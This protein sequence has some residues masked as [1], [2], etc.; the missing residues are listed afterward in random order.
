MK[1]FVRKKTENISS[2][3]KPKKKSIIKPK[4]SIDFHQFYLSRNEN[5]SSF[6]TS[7]MKKNSIS[8]PTKKKNK[9]NINPDAL[10]FETPYMLQKPKDFNGLCDDLKTLEIQNNINTNFRSILYDLDD[11]FDFA[12]MN[13]NLKIYDSNNDYN[14][15]AQ[16]LKIV[17]KIKILPEKRTMNDLLQ[18]V[19]YIT[20]TKLGK[21]FLEGF[22]KK[23][24]FEKLITFCGAEMK[25]KFFKKGETVFRI[26]D[27]PDNFYIILFGKVNILKPLPKII[28]ITGN[29]YFCYLMELKKSKDEYLYNLCIKA[30]K[31]NFRID[32]DDAK[33]LGYIYIYLILEKINRNKTVDFG[34]VLKLVDMSYKDFDLEPEH[35]KER[36]YII[37][38]MRKIKIYLPDIS[39]AII[40]KYLFLID[41]MTKK[42]ITLYYYSSFLTLES[43]SHFG[44]S[45]MDSNTTR[46]AT[47]AAAEDTHTAYISC[48]SYFKNVVVEKAA[49][50][51]KK[52]QFLNSNFIFGKINQK[53]FEKKYFGLFI[54]NNYKKGDIIFEE[55]DNPENV[56]FIEEGDIELYSSKNIYELQKVI[57]YLEEKRIKFLKSNNDELSEEKDYLFTYDKLH[58]EAYELRKDIIRKNKNTILVLNENE[59]LGLLSF[60]FGYPYFVTSMVRSATAKIYKIDNKYLSEMILKERVVYYELINRIEYK[61]ALFHERFFNINNTKLLLADHQKLIDTKERKYNNQNINSD[62]K[63]INNSEEITSYFQKNSFNKTI[64]R[65]DYGKL[66]QIF[67]KIQNRNINLNCSVKNFHQHRESS[68]FSTFFHRSNLPLISFQ[69]SLKVTD[70]NISTDKTFSLK[71]KT[72]EKNN[73]EGISNYNDNSTNEKNSLL[74]KGLSKK[75]TISAAVYIKKN[76]KHFNF[77]N[78]LFKNKSCM[79]LEEK[80]F[81]VDPVLKESYEYFEKMN[82]YK[83]KKIPISLIKQKGNTKKQKMKTQELF[84]K[85]YHRNRTIKIKHQLNNVKFSNYSVNNSITCK[86]GSFSINI[87]TKNSIKKEEKLDNNNISTI[88]QPN[89]INNIINYVQK[90]ALAKK[91]HTT[92]INHPYYSPLVLRKKEKYEILFHEGK[93]VTNKLSQ[94]NITHKSNN[95]KKSFNQL[96]YFFKFINKYNKDYP[97]KNSK[98]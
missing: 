85:H 90:D 16:I 14:N 25:Y 96:G 43:N 1:D 55:G 69:R 38:N 79:F 58:F 57:E 78:L 74:K 54:C 92:K 26:G 64:S 76:K 52:V 87:N 53:K 47:I 6:R 62:N 97:Y 70:N 27:L 61:L 29:Q 7:L 12:N 11:D 50:I 8:I 60:Y 3:L 23:E 84:K 2:S 32:V 88:K 77:S 93:T 28:S 40:S 31:V 35:L 9:K 37:E 36:K 10:V 15:I 75:S 46:N 67:N 71:N 66:K 95:K 41:V 33:D 73:D 18:I 13:K 45:A 83:Q 4:K 21:Y 68:K 72:L 65:I 80:K 22:E 98:G 39:N 42:E 81:C 19:K 5:I 20:T 34:E 24:I 59:D 44:D 82:K 56:Y 94:T 51:D 63:S 91:I 49:I 89:K 30:N 48:H 17:E 86:S